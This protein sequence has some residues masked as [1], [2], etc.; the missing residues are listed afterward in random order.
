[1]LRY[2]GRTFLLP[3]AKKL[4]TIAL[5]LR[6]AIL[7]DDEAKKAL[8]NLVKHGYD[9]DVLII[10][11]TMWARTP[12]VL[13]AETFR[14]KVPNRDAKRKL[15]S[16]AHTLSQAAEEIGE[17]AFQGELHNELDHHWIIKENGGAEAAERIRLLPETLRLYARVLTWKLYTE[18][19]LSRDD[20]TY[21]RYSAEQTR[22]F[23]DLVRQ[24][25]GKDR[26]DSVVLLFNCASRHFGLGKELEK[27]ALSQQLKR[28][29]KQPAAQS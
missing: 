7:E 28:L 13:F 23:F 15:E 25:T 2:K 10:H 19:R 14:S 12:K 22:I 5:G 27:K 26:V 17:D 3:P 20:K 29:R 18:S 1:M 4:G 6:K 11:L 16:L 9:P 24:R 8:D 21:L